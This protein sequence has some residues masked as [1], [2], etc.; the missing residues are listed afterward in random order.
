MLP[1][2][3]PFG[4]FPLCFI[5]YFLE[6]GGTGLA[7]GAVWVGSTNHEVV[8]MLRMACVLATGFF[9]GFVSPSFAATANKDAVTIQLDAEYGVELSTT[10][11]Q[12]GEVLCINATKE[13]RPQRALY[14]YIGQ[15]ES[16]TETPDIYTENA[17][18]AGCEATIRV[19]FEA[20]PGHYEFGLIQFGTGDEPSGAL[21][22]LPAT[23]TTL[24]E[25]A[26]ARI[27]IPIGIEVE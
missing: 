10:H 2:R 6:T 8:D 22:F 24:D 19:P 20:S 9:T 7:L 15:Y 3:R 11:L 25:P 14:A 23:G 27:L 4:A 16:T 5:E 17:V 21:F 18:T 26:V 13:V 1:V 12:R